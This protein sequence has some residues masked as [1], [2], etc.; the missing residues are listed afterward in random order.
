MDIKRYCLRCFI[1]ALLFSLTT[2]AGATLI[3][4]GDG[5][6]TD[7]DLGI[8][9]LQTPIVVDM[10]WPDAVTWA[11]SLIFAGYDDWRLPS[12]LN[13]SAST[14]DEFINS[15]DNEFGHL[16][17]LELGNPGG[18][19]DIAPLVDYYDLWFWSGTADGSDAFA[20][21]WSYDGLWYNQSTADRP[22]LSIE[23][24][25]HVTAVRDIS[26]DVDVPEPLSLALFGL[27]LAGICFL[28]RKKTS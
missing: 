27:G 28:Q 8:M 13:F 2:H 18:T 4:N 19:S 7:D 25:L 23:S 5:T 11:D 21:F 6:I 20:F 10:E 22:D 3:N 26:S 15:T 14:P 12:A 16:Y 17:G 9:W 24:V 1:I